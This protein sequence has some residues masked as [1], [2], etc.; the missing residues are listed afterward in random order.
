MSRQREGQ[1]GGGDECNHEGGGDEDERIEGSGPQVSQSPPSHP[2]KGQLKF[3]GGDREN[4][5]EAS[6]SDDDDDDK[7]A[8]RSSGRYGYEASWQQ[9]SPSQEEQD[10]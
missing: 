10:V 8:N 2:K 1:E 7:E 5:E 6:S 3:G 9:P 4:R